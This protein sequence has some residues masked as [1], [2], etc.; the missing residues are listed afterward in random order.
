[1]LTPDFQAIISSA[2]CAVR[3]AGPTSP[4]AAR[5]RRGVFVLNQ[6]PAANVAAQSWTLV[7]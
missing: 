1:M 5:P 2:A 7:L 4:C 3:Y 6:N